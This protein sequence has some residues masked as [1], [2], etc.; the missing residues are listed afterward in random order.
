MSALKTVLYM[1]RTLAVC[2]LRCMWSL[3]A[4]SDF[5]EEKVFLH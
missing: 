1:F 4:D 5:T 2:A 3:D